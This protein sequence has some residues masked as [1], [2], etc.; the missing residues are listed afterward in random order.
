MST[1]TQW[2]AILATLA[3]LWF[4]FVAAQPCRRRWLRSPVAIAVAAGW[5]VVG[6]AGWAIAAALALV[7]AA[8]HALIGPPAATLLGAMPAG[9]AH[10]AGPLTTNAHLLIAT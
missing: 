1:A 5:A 6:M 4:A 9:T 3:V 7:Y 2:A 8:T 10:A